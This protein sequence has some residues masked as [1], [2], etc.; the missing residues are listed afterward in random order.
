MLEQCLKKIVLPQAVLLLLKSQLQ[1]LALQQIFKKSF[2]LREALLI[3][4]RDLEIVEKLKAVAKELG[5][6]PTRDEFEKISGVGR[7]FYKHLTYNGLLKLAGLP[8]HP[9]Q[10]LS[11]IDVTQPVI[12]VLDIEVAPLKLWSFGIR[13]QY[14]GT[15]SIDEDWTILSFAARDI[16]TGEMIYHEVSPLSPRDDKDVVM[17]AFNLLNKVDVV[18]CHNARFDISMLRSRFLFYDLPETRPFRQICTLN[19]ARKYFR[20]TS[21]KL[22]YLARFLGVKEK[23]SHQNFAGMKLFSECANGNPEAFAELQAYNQRDVEVT[24]ECYYRLRKYDKSIRFNLFY[25]NN[26]CDCGSSEF[27]VLDPIYL[28]TGAFKV[29]QCLKCGKNHRSKEN[30]I[31]NHIRS[32]LTV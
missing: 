24:E 29:F 18:I 17:A 3:S 32:G 4:D 6:K 27:K 10:S 31:S 19:V 5:R 9:N 1:K 26:Q 21:N 15:E 2:P 7:Y 8:L 23:S 13:D 20:L 14:H 16:G 28:N 25:Q 11:K 12:V 30:L 22:E